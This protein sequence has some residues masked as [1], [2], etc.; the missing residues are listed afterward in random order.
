MGYA[1]ARGPC[2]CS[3]IRLVEPPN[4]VW[5]EWIRCWKHYDPITDDPKILE[6]AQNARIYE[7]TW[8]TRVG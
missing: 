8:K 5:I 3:H 1:T 7:A 4:D 2:G 6:A